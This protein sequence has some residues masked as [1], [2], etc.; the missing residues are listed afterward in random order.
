MADL[1]DYY[2]PTSQPYQHRILVFEANSLIGHRLIEYF[3][4]DHLIEVNPNVILGTIDSTLKYSNELGLDIVI[5]VSSIPHRP[6]TNLSLPLLWPQ[7]TS[8]S[9]PSPFI[10]PAPSSFYSN[11][12]S[13]PHSSQ[14]PQHNP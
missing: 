5:E 2:P 11:V 8:S 13:S 1:N 14:K 3:R 4:N 9:S 10:I 6:I 12:T 7:P